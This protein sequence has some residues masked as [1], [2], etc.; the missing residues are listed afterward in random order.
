M[1]ET[2]YHLLQLMNERDQRYGQ[3]FESIEMAVKVANTAMERRLEALNELRGAMVD[4]QSKFFSREEY[5]ARHE[6]LVN[7]ID[8]LKLTIGRSQGRFE[9]V[10]MTWA[11]IMGILMAAIDFMAGLW[12][13]H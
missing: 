5:A 9:G 12:G 10:K 3:R 1:P 6:T 4:Q 2:P 13:K 7:S 8:E 11:V